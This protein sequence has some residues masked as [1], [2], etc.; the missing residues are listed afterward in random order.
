MKWINIILIVAIIT[1]G[2]LELDAIKRFTDW[3]FISPFAA[4]IFVGSVLIF[5]ILNSARYLGGLFTKR[6]R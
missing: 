5:L 4:T 6:K 1:T 2:F 3:I